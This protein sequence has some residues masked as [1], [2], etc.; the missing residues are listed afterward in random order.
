MIFVYAFIQNLII[1]HIFVSIA[2]WSMCGQTFHYFNYLG[3][4][5]WGANENWRFVIAKLE[6]SYLGLDAILIHQEPSDW[7]SVNWVDHCL[8]ASSENSDFLYLVIQLFKIKYKN[9]FRIV[10]VMPSLHWEI[11]S[12]TLVRKIGLSFIAI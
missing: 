11:P 8:K 4:H 7:K 12:L 1:F 10:D 9:I 2:D 5:L 6:F 3:T